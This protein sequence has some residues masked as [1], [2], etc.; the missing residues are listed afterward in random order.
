[1]EMNKDVPQ[2]R[3]DYLDLLLTTPQ[4]SSEETKSFYEKIRAMLKDMPHLQIAV[5]P[6]PFLGKREPF[7]FKRGE[8]MDFFIHTYPDPYPRSNLMMHVVMQKMRED[9]TFKPVFH[10]SLEW[11]EYDEERLQESMKAM[12]IEFTNP[13]DHKEPKQ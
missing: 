6:N 3:I 10:Y 4:P 9:P 11:S 5:G 8:L 12:G 7:S 2:E 1:M 13:S